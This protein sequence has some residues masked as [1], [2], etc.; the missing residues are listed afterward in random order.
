M[1]MRTI[2]AKITDRD[3]QILQKRMREKGITMSEVIREFIRS[4]D[5]DH[6]AAMLEHLKNVERRLVD[7]NI[8]QL[9]NYLH[10]L[11]RIVIKNDMVLHHTVVRDHCK[12]KEEIAKFYEPIL[13]E[14]EERGFIKP[15]MGRKE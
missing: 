15:L 9:F 1:G 14:L 6:E 2:A 10:D 8:E 13:K 4:G 11:L 5:A 3:F 12:T 7:M